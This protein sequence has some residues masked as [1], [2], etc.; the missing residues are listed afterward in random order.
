MMTEKIIAPYPID[1]EFIQASLTVFKTHYQTSIEAYD[2]FII[3]ISGGNTPLPFF[4]ALA[5]PENAT[6]YDWEK[7]HFF[8]VDERIVSNHSPDNNFN[9]AYQALLR[10]VQVPYENKHRITTYKDPYLI[11]KEYEKEI[12]AL[13]VQTRKTSADEIPQ[14]DLIFLGMG[15]DGHTASLFPMSPA[16]NEEEK[17]IIAVK[18]PDTDQMRISM[19]YPLLEKAKAI[20]VMARGNKKLKLI[21]KIDAGRLPHLPM[22]KLKKKHPNIIWVTQ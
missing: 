12:R 22:A 11:A 1:E 4:E 13:F 14:F 6:Q 15:E 10:K 2:S 9:N 3:A 17:L 8:W 21:N 7:I 20:C 5:L 19:T 16:L 18:K